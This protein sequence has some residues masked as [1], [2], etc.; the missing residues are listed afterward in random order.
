MLRLPIL[1][2]GKGTGTMTITEQGGGYF[3]WEMNVFD[4][5]PFSSMDLVLGTAGNPKVFTLAT[6]A[7]YI[8]DEIVYFG[9]FTRDYLDQQLSANGFDES[10][11]YG[12]DQL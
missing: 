3:Y 6:A 10:A 12:G 4:V 5:G 9:N 8:E 2:Q 1:P 11:L 7:E